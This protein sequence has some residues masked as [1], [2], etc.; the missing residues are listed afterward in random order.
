[1]QE[2]FTAT[3]LQHL[4]LIL[5][6]ITPF[7]RR[8][9]KI[10]IQFNWLS[11][12]DNLAIEQE[13]NKH[14]KACG[15]TQGRITGIITFIS[16]LVLLITGVISIQNLGLWKTIW[17]YLILAVIAMLIGKAY[18]LLRARKSLR[19]LINSLSNRSPQSPIK[20]I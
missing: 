4:Y 19:Q 13:I 16:Y 6:D 17:I 10:Y 12:E 15:C 7:N 14:Y 18:G 1:M 9:K 2:H 5:E 3:D 20:S 11:R 8:Y